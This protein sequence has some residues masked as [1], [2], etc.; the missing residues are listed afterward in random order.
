MMFIIH[1]I[2][3]NVFLP[4]IYKYNHIFLKN[5]NEEGHGAKLTGYDAFYIIILTFIALAIRLWVIFHPDGPVFDE[6]HFGNFTNW[7]TKSQFFFDIHPPLGKLIMFAF[8]NLSEYDGNLPFH[9]TRKYPDCSYVSLRLTPAI[10]SA[11]CCP[12][13]YVTVRFS[14][15]GYISAITAATLMVTDTSMATEGRFILSDGMLHFFSCLHLAII[16]FTFSLRL[17]NR[18][19][20]AAWHVLTGLSLGAACSCKNTAWGLM[21]LDAFI[22]IVNFFPLTKIGIMDYLFE[23]FVYGSTLF[24]LNLFV[25]LA[26]FYVHFIVLPLSGQG[27]GYLPE[28]MKAQLIPLSAPNV[29]IMGR[30][31]QKPGLLYRSLKLTWIMHS[32]NMGI[33]N[34]HGSQSRPHNW[35]FLTGIDVGFWGG[36]GQEIKC[37]G[38][39]FSYY[40]AFLG[41]VLCAFPYKHELYMKGIRFTIGWMMCY[42]PFY[43]IPRT[44]YLYHY[45]I[46]LMI[47]CCAYG[48]ILEMILP[49]KLRGIVA[50][51]TWTLAWFG[52]WLWMPLVYGKYG[53]DRN[54]MYWNDNWLHGDAVYKSEQALDRQ[55]KR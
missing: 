11:L 10:F 47:G 18:K 42:F 17:Q 31:I 14:G 46:P 48:A 29:S 51:A 23:I 37:H 13:I 30:R 39:V 55:K 6:V 41:V 1:Q 45:L 50:F 35:P 33:R 52:F 49:K 22:Y 26:S 7:Y 34:F 3:F 9:N 25:Y 4:I 43:L 44:M 36:Y 28:N 38:N 16:S 32:G 2:N 12:L 21:G 24:L 27:K 19:K 40:F 8:S 53:H 20:F 5:M 54:I 15:F